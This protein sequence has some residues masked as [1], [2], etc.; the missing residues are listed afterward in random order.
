MSEEPAPTCTERVLVRWWERRSS[1]RLDTPPCPAVRL[2][3]EDGAPSASGSALANMRNCS[4]T[5]SP[6]DF[7]FSGGMSSWTGARVWFW[8]SMTISSTGSSAV[9]GAL[10]RLSEAICRP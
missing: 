9:A 8:L 5:I 1:R 10:G 4:M 6:S 2:P 7:S 3:V